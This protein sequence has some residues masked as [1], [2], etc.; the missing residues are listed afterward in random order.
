MK[1][2]IVVVTI[3]LHDNHLMREVFSFDKKQD[4]INF[5]DKVEAGELSCHYKTIEAE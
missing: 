3:F 4:A 5:I 2:H 1:I